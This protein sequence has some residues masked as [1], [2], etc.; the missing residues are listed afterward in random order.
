ME[1]LTAT[2]T[3]ITDNVN[4]T[5]E[6][7][8]ASHQKASQYA[9]QADNSREQMTALTDAMGRIN[10]TSTKIENIISDIEDI[11]KPDESVILKCSDRS[12]PCR[13]A[14]KGFAVVADQIRKLA[15]QSAQSAVDTRQLI[16][17]S[18]AG[19]RRGE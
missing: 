8:E 7:L 14:G 15:E 10:E 5:A 4:A 2:I 9:K 13:E 19:D 17:G 18:P 12:C 3:N 6:K 11:A 1:E 16:E